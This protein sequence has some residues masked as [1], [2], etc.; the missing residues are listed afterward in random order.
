MSP[1]LVAAAVVLILPA[2]WW[3][4]CGTRLAMCEGDLVIVQYWPLG[5]RVLGRLDGGAGHWWLVHAD[6]S[7]E[8]YA[9]ENAPAVLKVPT[10]VSAGK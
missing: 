10:K 5:Q 1:Y 2:V 4:S 3:G 6:G 7:T 8:P 9:W